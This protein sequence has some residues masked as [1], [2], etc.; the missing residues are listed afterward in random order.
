[1]GTALKRFALVMGNA[2]YVHAPPLN[3]PVNDAR[4]MAAALKKVGF[5]V[6][7]VENARDRRE[8]TDA[9]RRFGDQLRQGGIGHPITHKS[10]CEVKCPLCQ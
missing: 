9:V 10:L 2:A 4:D 8:M 7:Y 5:V 1:M 6:T 3:N